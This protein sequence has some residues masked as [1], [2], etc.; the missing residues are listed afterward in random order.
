[1]IAR[2]LLVL[3]VFAVIVAAMPLGAQRGERG[4]GGPG[5]GPPQ[6]PI[7][8][9]EFKPVKLMDPLKPIADAPFISARD[10][11]EQVRLEELVLGVEIGGQARAYPLNMLT[12]PEREIINDMVIVTW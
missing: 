5:A 11:K 9:S 3:A 12:G 1:M 10:V 4:R 6:G 8:I 2:R 7:D